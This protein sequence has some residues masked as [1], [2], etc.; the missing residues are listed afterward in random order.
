MTEL[1][2]DSVPT[3]GPI[4][5]MLINFQNGYPSEDFE[6]ECAIIQDTDNG[7]K[8][9]A[10]E[11]DD[12]VYYGNEQ[13]EDLGKTLILARDRKTGKV[14]LIEVGNAELIPYRK[15]DLNS[16]QQETSRL[17]LSRK[18]GS[19][20]QKQQME[21]REKLKSN[22]VTVTEQM[23]NVTAN[24]TADQLDLSSYNKTDSEDFYIPPM[25]KDATK[26]EEVYPIEQIMS[27]EDYEN[28]LTELK[29]VDFVEHYHPYIKSLVKGRT[30]SPQ[31]TVLAVYTSE[32]IKFTHVGCRDLLK[33]DFKVCDFSNTLNNIALKCFT[34]FNKGVRKQRVR[35]GYLKDKLICHIMVFVLILSNFK[36]MFEP[37]C[38]ALKMSP[39][40]QACLNKIRLIRA[41]VVHADGGKMLQLKLPLPAKATFL[42]RKSTKF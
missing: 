21:Q 30:Y 11:L 7:T 38:A 12:L 42:R 22:V 17:E 6:S 36:Y 34:E 24:V 9:I 16:S 13:N 25:D 40:S 2:I 39:K 37:L 31:L 1:T 4:Y 18:F 10:T 8:M 29:E 28:I 3:K 41:T 15:V 33:K 26:V 20:K 5:P 32:L 23:Q 14:R 19:K 27:E 35:P